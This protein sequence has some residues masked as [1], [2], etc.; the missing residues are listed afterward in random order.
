MSEDL[1]KHEIEPEVRQ[2]IWSK[3]KQNLKDWVWYMGE[4]PHWYDINIQG[5]VKRWVIYPIRD[6]IRHIKQLAHDDKHSRKPETD[7]RIGQ[8]LLFFWGNAPHVASKTAERLDLRRKRAAKAD[9]QRRSFFEHLQIHP[10]AFLGG[11]MS[12]AAVAVLLSLYTLGTTTTYNGVELGTVSGGKAVSAA[13]ANVEEITRATLQDTSYTIDEKLLTTKTGVVSRADVASTEELQQSLSDEIGLVSYG[14]ALYVDDELVAATPFAGALEELLEQL[15]VGYR[16]A[17]TVEISFVEK[18]EI[19]E[20]YVDSAYMMNL[21]NI[22]EIINTTKTGA[23]Y[24]T[25]K[26]GDSLYGIADDFG[27]TLSA[28]LAMN[29]GYQSSRLYPGDV[30]TMSTAIP[31][32]TVLNVE[33]QN[34][35]KDVPYPIDYQDDSGMYEGDYRVL[36]PGVPGKADITANVSFVNGVETAREVVASVTLRQPVNELQARGTTPRPSWYPT[37]SFRWP[38]S[39]VITSYFGYR[40]EPIAGASS[41]HGAL[42]IANSHGTPIY[43]ADGG[44]VIYAGWNGGYGYLIKI[45]HVNTGLVTYYAHCS[46]L[47]VSVGDRVYKGEHIAAMGSTGLSTGSHLHFGVQLHGTFVDPLD[48]LP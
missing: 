37:G 28:L 39:G 5:A 20:G 14:Y 11:A 36:S 21:G 16:T 2:S 23:T 25:V 43:A 32:L 34:Y 10:A 41:N 24:Y 19:R 7:S 12:I 17:N 26:S 1:K 27:I 48:Y 6:L 22:A 4:H 40:D 8:L 45:D 47:Y 13:V 18:V 9:S 15:K 29:P 46:E 33:R 42:D 35:V 44:E 30:L 3:W 31:Y 38:T